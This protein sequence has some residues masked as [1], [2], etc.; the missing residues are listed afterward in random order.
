MN[1]IILFATYW[2]EIDWI[3]PSLK[4]IEKLD[5]KE[6][7]ICDGCFDPRVTPVSSTDGTHEIIKEW[8]RKRKHARMMQPIRTNRLDAFVKLVYGNSKLPWYHRLYP[9]H[10]AVA[11]LSLKKSIYRVNQALTF[12]KMIAMSKTWRIGDWLMNYDCDQFYSDDMI[13]KIIA[14]CNG[15]V[16][17]DLLTGKERSFFTGFDAYTEDYDKRVYNNMPHRIRKDMW[18]VPTREIVV[19]KPCMYKNYLSAVKS[20]PIGHYFHYK[21]KKDSKRYKQGYQ[22]GDR[23]APQ[24]KNFTF[25]KIE[26][27]D[28]PSII[29]SCMEDFS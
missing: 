12:N 23:K 6:V 27:K 19:E 20:K 22:L 5:P 15:E 10:L 26:K 17:A 7:I 16:E 18:I 4:Q 9:I 14:Y 29:R 25:K 3:R 2:N 28:H 11:L 13:K 21:F 1:N 24:V 8:V